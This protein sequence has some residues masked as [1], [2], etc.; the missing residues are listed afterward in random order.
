[1]VGPVLGCPHYRRACK[2]RAVCCGKLFTCRLCHDQVRLVMDHTMDRYNVREML[3]MR[4]GALQPVAPD[5]Q[6]SACCAYPPPL[7]TAADATAA[8]AMAKVAA[9]EPYH[10]GICRLFDDA[11]DKSIYHCPYCNVCRLGKGLGVDFWHCMRC[12]ACISTGVADHKC[13]TH[14]LESDCPICGV[15]MFTSTEP[16]KG[17]QCGHFLHLDCYREYIFR[18]D[19]F[20]HGQAF[21]YRCP[22][23]LK[24][25][26]DMTEYF[27]QLDAV[28][29]SQPMPAEYAGWTATVLCH[30]CEAYTLVPYHFCYHKC[31]NAACSSYNTRV[32]AQQ[33]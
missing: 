1:M 25:M 20:Q 14:S 11:P 21:W 7:A 12:N 16:V 24:S 9:R 30:D 2:L 8:V 18:A 17:L 15:S 29:A 23:C 4:C 5:C 26:E 27:S 28:V 32:E 22:I 6:N 31:G 3:C 10:C 33:P 19:H 13:I